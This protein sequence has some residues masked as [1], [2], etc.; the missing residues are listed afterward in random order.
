MAFIAVYIANPDKK[1]AKMVA[2]HLL[3]NGL[4]ACVNIFPA[5]SSYRWKGKIECAKEFA[6][7]AKT[8]QENFEKIKQEIKKIHPYECPE[9]M[10]IV[11]EANEEYEN[12]VKKECMSQ[13]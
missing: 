10:K 1:T 6:A 4:A 13:S 2:A 7:L 5:E 12:W 8:T 9:V 3:E 11:A